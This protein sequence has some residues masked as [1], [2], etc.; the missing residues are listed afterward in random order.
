MEY[1]LARDKRA[2]EQTEGERELRNKPLPSESPALM[3]IDRR[4]PFLPESSAKD[5]LAL[6][7]ALPEESPAV[8]TPHPNSSPSH[9]PQYN[10]EDARVE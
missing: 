2:R 5:L 6:A 7:D 8:V 10:Q 1:I 4:S 3:H 9:M